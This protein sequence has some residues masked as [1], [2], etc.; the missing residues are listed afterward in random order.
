TGLGERLARAHADVTGPVLQVGMDTPQLTADLLHRTSSLA[1]DEAIRSLYF[2][3]LAEGTDQGFEI[4]P[5][6][7]GALAESGQIFRI[8]RQRA[9]NGL[10]HDLRNGS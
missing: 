2:S 6:F 8:F 5:G 1:A 3:T 7:L 9:T 10:V 4:E